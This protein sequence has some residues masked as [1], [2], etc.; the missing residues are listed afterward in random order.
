MHIVFRN[1][2]FMEVLLLFMNV[3]FL[4]KAGASTWQ[5][6][7]A[8]CWWCGSSGS[9][10][11]C[12]CPVSWIEIFST[13]Y[14]PVTIMMWCLEMQLWSILAWGGVW[15]WGPPWRPC[16]TAPSCTRGCGCWRCTDPASASPPHTHPR[17]WQPSP[18]RPGTT[19]CSR[20]GRQAHLDHCHCH[21][22]WTPQILHS[23]APRCE[24]ASSPPCWQSHLSQYRGRSLRLSSNGQWGIWNMNNSISLA[25]LESNYHGSPWAGK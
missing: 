5:Y 9:G 2:S 10:A 4:W 3:Q 18:S 16:S 17:W 7:P 12:P 19:E 25:T 22:Q 8:A 15:L 20:N 23:A 24:A 13:Q 1:S 6:S 11:A 21:H 14:F